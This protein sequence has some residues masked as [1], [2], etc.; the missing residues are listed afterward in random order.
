MKPAENKEEQR[1]Y[2]F[3]DLYRNGFEM[4]VIDNGQT[5]LAMSLFDII[6]KLDFLNV[7]E[8]SRLIMNPALVCAANCFFQSLS[9]KDVRRD[10]EANMSGRYIMQ[11]I[12]CLWMQVK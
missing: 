7:P 5:F 10:L 8:I 6:E 2:M 9:T 1:T 11:N 3:G 4:L 12:L